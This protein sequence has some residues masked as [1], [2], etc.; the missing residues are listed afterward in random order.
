MRLFNP[1]FCTVILSFLIACGSSKKE[2]KNKTAAI[3]KEE[4]ILGS[5]NAQWTKANPEEGF[6]GNQ[7]KMDGKM[8]FNEDGVKITVYGFDGC[9][10]FADTVVSNLKW[11]IED[12]VIRFIDLSDDQGLPYNIESITNQEV[13]LSLMEDI[14]ITLK[15]NDR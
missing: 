1:V 13:K 3:P 5:W 9:I 4:I 7:L 10:F 8:V 12:S 2:E 6:T 15:R 14:Y 11:K